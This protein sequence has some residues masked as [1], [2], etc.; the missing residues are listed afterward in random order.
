MGAEEVCRATTTVSANVQ[1]PAR[2]LSCCCLP[3][4]AGERRSQSCSRSCTSLS[5]N[6]IETQWLFLM[7]QVQVVASSQV[8]LRRRQC[9][10][11]CSPLRKSAR[12]LSVE[13]CQ[14]RVVPLS[15]S[16]RS[17]DTMVCATGRHR[18]SRNAR[19]AM[20]YHAVAGRGRSRAVLAVLPTIATLQRYHR[21]DRC[22]FV[23]SDHNPRVGHCTGGTLRRYLGLWA[24][25]GF[26]TSAG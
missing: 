13:R 14:I 3:Q 10:H 11:S 17:G 7:V 15:T 5:D 26:P 4:S 25:C 19:D 9:S 20:R 21:L 2:G 24:G 12:V 22:W 23:V 8:L 16:G 6:P 1:R 18:T